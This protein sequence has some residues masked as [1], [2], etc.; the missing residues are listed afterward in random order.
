MHTCIHASLHS[1][2]ITKIDR[3]NGSALEICQQMLSSGVSWIF[4][5]CQ[6]LTSDKARERT[7]SINRLKELLADKK[8][9]T[10]LNSD[11][12]TR[13]IVAYFKMLLIETKYLKGEL[14]TT[15]EAKLRLLLRDARTLLTL[16]LP[17]AALGDNVDEVMETM[18]AML[19]NPLLASLHAEVLMVLNTLLAS[20][21]HLFLLY[22]GHTQTLLHYCKEKLMHGSRGLDGECAKTVTNLAIYYYEINGVK[23]M[24]DIAQ[25]SL[26][27]LTKEDPQVMDSS[28][29]LNLS[30][31]FRQ[32]ITGLGEVY[33]VFCRSILQSWLHFLEFNMAKKKNIFEEVIVTLASAH[34]CLKWDDTCL[35]RVKAFLI[36]ESSWGRFK[37]ESLNPLEC[38]EIGNASLKNFLKVL[39][40]YTPVNLSDYKPSKSFIYFP[41]LVFFAQSLNT[42]RNKQVE[43]AESLL[44]QV[45][46][47]GSLLLQVSPKNQSWLFVSLGLLDGY[48]PPEFIKKLAIDSL[49]RS[50]V[51]DAAA[52]FLAKQK[53][54]IFDLP[55]KLLGSSLNK[56]TIELLEQSFQARFESVL[57]AKSAVNAYAEA[58]NFFL[59]ALDRDPKNLPLQLY[60]ILPYACKFFLNPI[61]NDGAYK[62]VL[63]HFLDNFEELIDEVGC[64]PFQSFL[65]SRWG[66]PRLGSDYAIVCLNI[67]LKLISK[68]IRGTGD[69]SESPVELANLSK[70]YQFVNWILDCLIVMVTNCT[71]YYKLGISDLVG[72]L[73][74]NYNSSG[75]K[76]DAMDFFLQGQQD[77]SI[78][79]LSAMIGIYNV[80]CQI[81]DIDCDLELLAVRTDC[82]AFILEKLGDPS[83]GGDVAAQLIRQLPFIPQDCK[84]ELNIVMAK[85]RESFSV[86]SFFEICCH[87]QYKHFMSTYFESFNS[88]EMPTKCRK[89]LLSLVTN[90]DEI[91]KFVSKDEVCVSIL[92]ETLFKFPTCSLIASKKI[93]DCDEIPSLIFRS[94]YTSSCNQELLF[95]INNA[96]LEATM[97]VDLHETQWMVNELL[98]T[99]VHRQNALQFLNCNGPV[100]P[101]LEMLLG[102]NN[103]RN[104]DT[105]VWNISATIMSNSFSPRLAQALLDH[106]AGARQVE[107][108]A[109]AI[110]D[111]KNHFGKAQFEELFKVNFVQ[112]AA[113]ILV[114]GHA[115][116]SSESGKAFL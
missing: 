13:A 59:N 88:M 31:A 47:A 44:L 106:H 115:Q 62:P 24:K 2:I 35:N 30:R 1:C 61:D 23:L 69:A 79:R 50:I 95:T 53:L 28:S 105:S 52:F 83:L 34:T 87:P 75:D 16:L 76:Q 19:K 58:L 102:G 15:V 40:V 86:E 49:G 17:V 10:R 57:W 55:A 43:I 32:C 26:N 45:E 36:N 80:L 12:A 38:I 98:A 110:Q 94:K 107:K 8:Q 63:E 54:H 42:K 92:T 51:S 112:T 108:A 89:R 21:R 39:S 90:H 29:L 7:E 77:S 111:L 78:D 18:L 103:P 4:P 96:L 9:F 20:S 37:L 99:P 67:P 14:G 74:Q 91:P 70:P 116:K 60:T 64:E 104:T 66:D 109:A 101:V 25:L 82:C 27:I 41:I 48:I 56:Q 46:L 113:Y 71:D 100:A 114:L 72:L 81:K 5:I 11:D 65:S 97:T 68:R 33:P 93:I 84:T 85:L 73:I 3:D 22:S 6:H